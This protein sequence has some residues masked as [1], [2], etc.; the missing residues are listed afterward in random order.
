MHPTIP[1]CHRT[2]RWG[3]WRPF[4]RRSQC[5]SEPAP[6]RA[7]SLKVDSRESD[8][9]TAVRRPP[10]ECPAGNMVPN[11]A[12]VGSEVVGSMS[13]RSKT[14]ALSSRRA[15]THVELFSSCRLEALCVAREC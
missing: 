9:M 2:G 15:G 5:A 10:L 12:S 11:G 14:C 1:F 13:S 8:T 7:L 3:V 4:E 6:Q